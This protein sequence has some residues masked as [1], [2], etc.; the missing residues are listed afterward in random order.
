MWC[1]RGWQACLEQQQQELASIGLALKGQ[2]RLASRPSD[3]SN[4][5]IGLFFLWLHYERK[6]VAIYIL[7]KWRSRVQLSFQTSRLK[8]ATTAGDRQA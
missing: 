6:L 1:T 4:K 3:I 7:A 5:C 8:A 2:Q